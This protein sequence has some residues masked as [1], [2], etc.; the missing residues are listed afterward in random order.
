[1]NAPLV[2]LIEV[3]VIFLLGFAVGYAVRANV[4]HRRHRRART[5][6]DMSGSVH[7]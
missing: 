2:A 6:R 7:S 4:S 3:G 5:L 1:M